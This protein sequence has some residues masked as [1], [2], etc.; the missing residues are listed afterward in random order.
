MVQVDITE[1]TKHLQL[2]LRSRG[3]PYMR[4][5]SPSCTKW[6]T[7]EDCCTR[8]THWQTYNLR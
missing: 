5:L 7:P 4:G 1:P 6:A 2:K 8:I 3:T